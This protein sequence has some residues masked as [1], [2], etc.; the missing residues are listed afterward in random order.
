MRS[1][2]AAR[3][4]RTRVAA[5]ADAVVSADPE[6]VRQALSDL[7]DSRRALAPIGWT[8]GTL[9]LML[10]GARTIVTNW[11]LML[12]ELTP[13]LWIGVTWWDLRVHALKRLELTPVH[14]LDL[15]IIAI[16]VIAITI[17]SYWCNATFALTLA[18]EATGS[19]RNAFS[20]SRLHARSIMWW[21]LGVGV[22]HAVVS[23]LVVRV[24][25]LAF[26]LSM[27]LVATVMMI[28]F[29]TVPARLLGAQTKQPFSTRISGTA[30]GGM[31]SVV[32]QMPGFLLNRLGLLLL[33][34]PVLVI[35]GIAMFATGV[36]LQTA[37]ISSV[38]AVKLST[39][40]VARGSIAS[41][42]SSDRGAA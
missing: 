8:L 2:D 37:A 6:Q 19:I 22:A 28:S 36:A 33:G 7:A 30:V 4:A 9:L 23:T 10:E 20:A 13:A 17:A 27:G 5:L 41:G 24:G 12:I 42:V 34:V 26:S 39:K 15:A 21:G 38:T 16:G 32:A 35:P 25:L 1:H 31:L 14:G 18:P 11:R 3:R 40:F 29:V